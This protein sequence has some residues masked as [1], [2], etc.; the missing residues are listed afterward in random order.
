[1]ADASNPPQNH[2][3]SRIRRDDGLKYWESVDATVDGMRMS[4]SNCLYP[5]QLARKQSEAPV[6][7]NTPGTPKLEELW[8]KLLGT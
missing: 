4:N 6:S 8:L 3:D 2:A 7:R 5:F 1:M